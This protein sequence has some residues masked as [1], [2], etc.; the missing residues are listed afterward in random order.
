MRPYARRPDAGPFDAL[1]AVGRAERG[2]AK[3][4]AR[5]R[6]RERYVETTWEIETAARHAGRGAVPEL[7][8]RARPSPPRCAPAARSCSAPAG[9]DARGVAYFHLAGPR[10][11]YVVVLPDGGPGQ[12][13]ARRVARKP[14]APRAGPTLLIALPH[15]A[16]LRARI[17]PGRGRGRRRRA[18][19][20]RPSPRLTP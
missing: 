9:V 14:S 1:R 8:R 13:R 17:A 2:G 18:V 12:A 6:F 20:A 11:G 15:G 19:A 10:G 7:G 5:H 16:G 3:V 4:T